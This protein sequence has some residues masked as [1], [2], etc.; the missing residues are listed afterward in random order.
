MAGSPEAPDAGGAAPAARR[1]RRPFRAVLLLFATLVVLA[2]AALV[3]AYLW[4]LDLY[5]RP[6]PLTDETAVVVPRGSGLSAIAQ[7]LER[8]GVISDARLFAL[9]AKIEDQAGNLKAGEY[10]F[11]A[12]VSMQ[13]V[14][15]LLVEGRTVQH[16]IT[17]PEGRTS[18]E[19]VQ[20]IN[21]DPVLEGPPLESLPPEGSLLPDTYFFQRGET[22][23]G[24]LQRM[25]DAQEAALAEL[26][27][28]R[29]PDLP[30]DTPEE[31]I[32]LAS[33]VEKETG[34]AGERALVAGVFVNRLKRGMRLQSD[35][36]VIYAVTK[37]VGGPLGRG[38]RR[39][40][41]DS[42]DPYNTYA[43]AGLPPGPIANPGREAL[44]ATIRPEG[45]DFLYFVADGTGGHAFSKT[46]AEHQR[47]VRDWRRIERQ[48][49]QEAGE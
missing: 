25:R 23:A 3:G 24:L 29:E 6:G 16:R 5:Q 12:A 30:F 40:E 44:A 32:T 42:G 31:W 43:V 21:A 34:L 15:A 46:L 14:L 36:T 45:T 13:Q 20:L 19:V 26:W 2:S 10:L 39:S 22:R 35:P 1:R 48:R 33:I 47:K 41:L 38:I 49:Q 18:W 37:G 27:P 28:T 4:G 8:E 9:A 17:V 11:P 7:R